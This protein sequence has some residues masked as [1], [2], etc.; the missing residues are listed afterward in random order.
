MRDAC[1]LRAAAALTFELHTITDKRHEHKARS[2]PF[3]LSEHFSHAP[4]AVVPT[5]AD[6]SS[7]R[8][9]S[10]VA[11][12][13]SSALTSHLTPD[14]S[15]SYIMQWSFMHSPSMEITNQ[16][17]RLEPDPAVSRLHDPGLGSRGSADA[18]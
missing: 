18:G 7:T 15:P 11:T 9:L 10:L 6:H 3:P 12:F 14:S 17:A 1:I 13:V 16:T 8:H 4:T 5:F 2:I